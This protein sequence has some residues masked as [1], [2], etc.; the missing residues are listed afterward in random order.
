M[1]VSYVLTVF[2]KR[3]FL[4]ATLSAVA[5][6]RSATGGEVILVDDGPRDGSAALLD[7]FAATHPAARVVRQANAGVAAATNRGLAAA[8]YDW[9][10][11]LDA[12][13][14]PV[15]GSTARLRAAL[16]DSGAD[17]AY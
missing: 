16:E 9:V 4:P 11:L 7:E 2:D 13:D 3:P 15:P 5:A 12:D 17:L 1:S 14:I 8:R 6:E 10:R